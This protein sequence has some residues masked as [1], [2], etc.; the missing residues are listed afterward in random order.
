MREGEGRGDS[1]VATR[2]ATASISSSD[3]PL[4]S[5]PFLLRSFCGAPPSIDPVPGD[6]P[7]PSPD[8]VDRGG[9]LVRP[10]PHFFTQSSSFTETSFN[11]ISRD[12]DK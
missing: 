1:P 10:L 7:S 5:P 3:V 4:Q 9:V 8:V 11:G 6:R 2:R 12:K